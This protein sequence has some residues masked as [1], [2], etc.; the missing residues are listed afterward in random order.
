MYA[1]VR[2]SYIPRRHKTVVVCTLR[3]A[4][5]SQLLNS[6][7]DSVKESE[8]MIWRIFEIVFEL[9]AFAFFALHDYQQADFLM[10]FLIYHRLIKEA[11]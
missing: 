3:R 1:G 2:A 8:V 7:L 9:I 5:T 6:F 4:C 10:L 11:K